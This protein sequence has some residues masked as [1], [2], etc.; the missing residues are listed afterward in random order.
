M[1]SIEEFNTIV[2]MNNANKTREFLKIDKRLWTRDIQNDNYNYAI[3]LS[4]AI[5]GFSIDYITNPG[6]GVRPTYVLD[7]SKVNVEVTGLLDYK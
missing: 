1:P 7:T 3:D 6:F 4:Y 2:D 5:A